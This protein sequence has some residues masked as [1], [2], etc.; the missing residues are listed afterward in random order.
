MDFRIISNDQIISNYQVTSTYRIILNCR[1]LLYYQVVR[2]HCIILHQLLTGTSIENTQHQIPNKS[3]HL[4]G[5]FWLLF[6]VSIR[7]SQPFFFNP[8]LYSVFPKAN[9]TGTPKYTI[10]N[11][12]RSFKIKR[13]TSKI[14]NT[15]SQIPNILSQ[16]QNTQPKIQ[17][18][19][20]QNQ[21]HPRNRNRIG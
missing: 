6:C 14:S 3:K 20:P 15:L 18:T 19:Q 11:P 10:Q 1:I 16:I 9:C 17:N 4:K 21:L 12:N 13:K 7:V 2:N 8:H 5:R